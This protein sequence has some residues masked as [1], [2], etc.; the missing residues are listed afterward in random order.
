MVH[1]FFDF[2]TMIVLARCA[3]CFAF[4]RQHTNDRN[5]LGREKFVVSQPS[6][7]TRPQTANP[8]PVRQT[9]RSPGA[10]NANSLPLRLTKSKPRLAAFDLSDQSVRHRET[11]ALPSKQNRRS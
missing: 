10:T 5:R 4:R 7:E 9:E 3:S 8:S 1:S 6:P 11:T 2:P